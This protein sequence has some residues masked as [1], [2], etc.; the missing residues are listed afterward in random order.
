LTVAHWS[1]LRATLTAAPC[2][3]AVIALLRGT[4]ALAAASLFLAPVS[5]HAQSA[6]AQARGAQTPATFSRVVDGDTADVVLSNGQLKQF[7][8]LATRYDKTA[9]AYHALVLLAA[10]MLWL[11]G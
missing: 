6:P 2:H 7:R 5:A 8:A 3:R 1:H 11:P 4:S 9:N 10:L